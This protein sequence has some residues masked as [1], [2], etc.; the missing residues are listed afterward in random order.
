METVGRG[1]ARLIGRK[2]GADGGKSGT[3]SSSGRRLHCSGELEVTASGDG[4]VPSRCAGETAARGLP[5]AV[6][7]SRSLDADSAKSAEEVTAR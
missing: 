7:R 4:G 6:V 5:A 2:G 1:S 3:S